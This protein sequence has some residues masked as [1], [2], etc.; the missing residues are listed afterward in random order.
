MWKHTG[1]WKVFGSNAI[2]CFLLCDVLVWTMHRTGWFKAVMDVLGRNEW[3]SLLY[4]VAVSRQNRRNT[5]RP[6]AAR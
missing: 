1:F 3:T 6:A 5:A 2:L 4:A